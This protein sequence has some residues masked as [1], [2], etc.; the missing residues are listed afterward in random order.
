MIAADTLN[1]E[2]VNV[3]WTPAGGPSRV[4]Q[5]FVRFRDG[6]H[7]LLIGGTF[8]ERAQQY[9]H[10]ECALNRDPATNVTFRNLGWSADTVF[11]ESRGIFDTPEK[12]YERLVEHVRAEEPSVILLCYGQNEAMSF[13]DGEAGIARFKHQLKQLHADLSTTNAEIIFLTPHPFLAMPEPLP[14]PTS[15]NGRLKQ[16]ADAVRQTAE[17]LDAHAVD[18]FTNFVEDMAER[19]QSLGHSRPLPP[20]LQQHPELALARNMAW[21]DNGMHWNDAG[22]RAASAVVGDRVTGIDGRSPTVKL[23]LAYP[24]ARCVA[25]VLRNEV[26]SPSPN[27]LAT[28]QCRAEVVSSFPTTVVF[29]GSTSNVQ[30]ELSHAE[31]KDS[32]QILKSTLPLG[33]AADDAGH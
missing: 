33:T 24:S 23:N 4:E 29:K 8:I 21:T 32:V 18:L 13:E 22:Y 5:G 7:V 30:V 15:W 16:Y 1:G 11:A 17:S 2:V 25:G 28:L 26:R 3:A 31:D 12:G 10:L 27:V 9:G 14:D 20:D 6:D 19:D